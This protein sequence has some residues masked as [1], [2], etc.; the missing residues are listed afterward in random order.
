MNT[1]IDLYKIGTAA[2]LAVALNG[3]GG[4][5]APGA[6]ALDI[7]SVVADGAGDIAGAVVPVPF[8]GV[9]FDLLAESMQIAADYQREAARD[10]APEPAGSTPASSA[11]REGPV[12]LM[13]PIS[14][15]GNR[16]T[17]DVALPCDLMA[18]VA[19]DGMTQQ[20]RPCRGI[21]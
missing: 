17:G 16:Q 10:E 20:S 11:G 12:P 4:G 18:R 14:S 2:L 3:C 9:P 21:Y 5:G 19:Y 7:G 6:A 8:A 1:G 13:G 15:R